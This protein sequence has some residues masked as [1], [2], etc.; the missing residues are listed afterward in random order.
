MGA[1]GRPEIRGGSRSNQP[2]N[3]ALRGA[4]AGDL[5]LR[6]RQTGVTGQFLNIAEAATSL[7][8]PLGKRR[9]KR[10][11]APVRGCPL[12]PDLPKPRKEPDGNRIGAVTVSPLA[13]HD[14]KVRPHLI[15]SDR[16]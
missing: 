14:G 11:P 6:R 5:P 1:R 7:G 13:I 15:A 2:D 9:Y 3:V 10:S 16:H 4:V 12:N 8:D